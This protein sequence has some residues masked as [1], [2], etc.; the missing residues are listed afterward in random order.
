MYLVVKG[1]KSVVDEEW[2]S[3]T[4]FFFFFFFEQPKHQT[5]GLFVKGNMTEYINKVIGRDVCEDK[6]RT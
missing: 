2:S 4:R 6:I 1:Y 5:N 3:L